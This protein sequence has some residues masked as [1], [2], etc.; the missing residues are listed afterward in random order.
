MQINHIINYA[1]SFLEFFEQGRVWR[2]FF[3]GFGDYNIYGISQKL[4]RIQGISRKSKKPI[5]LWNHSK[6]HQKH[7]NLH[8]KRLKIDIFLE[9]NQ[10]TPNIWKRGFSR[11]QLFPCRILMVIKD[12]LGCSGV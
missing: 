6:T 2:G 5:H 9:K 10:H 12:Y 7:Q 11:Q 8:Q 4:P 1:N 3:G